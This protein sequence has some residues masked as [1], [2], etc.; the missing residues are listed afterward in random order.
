MKKVLVYAAVA[1][2]VAAVGLY[3]TIDLLTQGAPD[4]S[5]STQL[6]AAIV[7]HLSDS[8][9]NQ[10]FVDRS[11]ALLEGAGFA[12]DYYD[13]GSVT[14]DLYRNL[15]THCYSLILLRVHSASF[16]PDE[17]VFDLF[18]S[19]SYSRSKYVSEQLSDQL[20]RCAFD[21]TDNPY[22]EGVSPE[23]FGVTH[24]FV[25]LSMRG[26]FHDTVVLMMGCDGMRY[27]E[28]AEAFVEKGA[29]VYIGWDRL[30]SGSH[31][32]KATVDLLT[33][34]LH[35]GQTVGEAIDCTMED[36]GPDP[37]YQSVL[38]HYPADAGNC[39]FNDIAGDLS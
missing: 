15:P 10:T 27:E 36:F 6:R 3:F 19:E 12:V 7:D 9:G 4:C 39:T 28:M 34:F 2:V 5:R 25:R 32:D 11:T 29:R 31:T 8:Q 16:N 18:T 23:Y 17:P 13:S 37:T 22:V 38:S 33:R 26:M 20:R 35:A 30:V 21:T 24:K 1:V 14:V